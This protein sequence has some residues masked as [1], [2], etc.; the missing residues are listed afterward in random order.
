MMD[1]CPPGYLEHFSNKSP[2]GRIG[3]AAEVAEV[4]AF[5]ASP[6]SSWVS[7]THILAHGAAI[8]D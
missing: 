6:A 5:L 1:S 2:M 3:T 7:G 4:V 8:P